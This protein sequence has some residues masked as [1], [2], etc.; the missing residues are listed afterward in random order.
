MSD[1]LYSIWMTFE[2]KIVIADV[3]I[4]LIFRSF[5]ALPLKLFRVR[6]TPTSG[7]S[8]SLGPGSFDA[9]GNDWF[10]S[11]DSSTA[12]LRPI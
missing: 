1:F 8:A 6:L 7:V 11:K 3:S 10:P 4:S 2:N 12:G 9:F 5:V